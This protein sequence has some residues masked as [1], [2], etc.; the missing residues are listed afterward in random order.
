MAIVAQ[1]IGVVV[2]YHAVNVAD[3]VRRIYPRY[4]IHVLVPAHRRRLATSRL[5]RG[6]TGGEELRTVQS[7]NREPFW[8][9]LKMKPNKP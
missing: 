9:K 7:K 8:Y 6:D 3:R 1:L 2:P 5:E 4:R